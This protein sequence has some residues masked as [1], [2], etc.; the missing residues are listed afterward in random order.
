MQNVLALRATITLSMQLIASINKN[1][2]VFVLSLVLA[3]SYFNIRFRCRALCLRLRVCTVNLILASLMHMR[4]SRL[5][6]SFKL[7]CA[8]F[9]LPSLD[10]IT[11]NL[12]MFHFHFF[13]NYESRLSFLYCSTIQC[14]FNI[15][16]KIFFKEMTK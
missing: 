16:K 14:V 7:R 11:R 4:D 3:L 2:I 15:F 12:K 10:L 6:S 1:S 9:H 13:C 8:M 5:F